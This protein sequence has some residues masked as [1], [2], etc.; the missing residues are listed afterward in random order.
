MIGKD[1]IAILSY[2][3][4]ENTPLY[5]NGSGITFTPEKEI[6]KG[7]SCNTSQVILPSH[8]GTH[9]DLPYHIYPEGKKLN[10]FPAEFWVFNQVEIINLTG[11]LSDCQIINPEMFPM[12]EN[13]ETD[14]ILLKTGYG[15]YRGMDR[16]TLTP[17]GISSD[18]AAYL[19]HELPKLRC[20]GMDLISISSYSNRDE[21]RKA[22]QAFLNPT[23]G[24]PIL[25]IEDMKLDENGPF[26]KILIAPLLIDKADGAP[27]TV[28][29]FS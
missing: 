2:Y 27:C 12:I 18:L 10:D 3:L 14:L 21:G 17:P 28:F 19:R 13:S 6:I 4:S 29:A 16:Y 7:D 8:S 20:L 1:R 15:S 25:L 24:E 22:H 23:E 9:L 5:G 11:K 26:N